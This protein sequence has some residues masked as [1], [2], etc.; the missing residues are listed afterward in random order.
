MD[1]DDSQQAIIAEA[2]MTEEQTQ[3]NNLDFAANQNQN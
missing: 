2:C 3:R 1:I